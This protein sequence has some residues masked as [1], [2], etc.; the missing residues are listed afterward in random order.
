MKPLRVLIVDDSSLTLELF[1]EILSAM[2]CDCV[3]SATASEAM[4]EI[5]RQAPDLVISDWDLGSVLSGVDVAK[6]LRLHAPH[7]H[8]VM[9]TGR[10]LAPLVDQT[11]GLDVLAYLKKPFAMSDLSAL[12]EGLEPIA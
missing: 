5:D 11:G 9:I 6:H 3:G 12:I 7:T 10:E 1:V 8:L 2:G 4:A